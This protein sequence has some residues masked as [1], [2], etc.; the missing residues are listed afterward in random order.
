MVTLAI[1]GQGVILA[2]GGI[3]LD[4]VHVSYAGH[5]ANHSS[6]LRPCQS[7]FLSCQKV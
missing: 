7:L 3:T 4:L 6:W 5:G 1:W 2:C